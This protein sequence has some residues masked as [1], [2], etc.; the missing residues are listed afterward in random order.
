MGDLVDKL[1]FLECYTR[2][3]EKRVEMDNLLR[4]MSNE[5]VIVPY[6]KGSKYHYTLYFCAL[7]VLDPLDSL[8]FEDHE[9]E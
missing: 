3:T 9:C 4:R 5:C 7:V 6:Q 8:N 2:E 1:D